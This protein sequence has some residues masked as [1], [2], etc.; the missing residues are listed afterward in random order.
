MTKLPLRLFAA[1][2]LIS[3]SGCGVLP[4]LSSQ[5]GNSYIYAERHE[6]VER[7]TLSWGRDTVELDAQNATVKN[8]QLRGATDSYST[9]KYGP[10]AYSSHLRHVSELENTKAVVSWTTRSGALHSLTLD[11]PK[12]LK[13]RTLH[14]RGFRFEVKESQV[15]VRYGK[16]DTFGTYQYNNGRCYSEL[17]YDEVI[18]K[19][20]AGA[21]TSH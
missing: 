21:A 8:P 15:V 11:I 17:N 1:S 3:L 16:T 9:R 12:A 5:E 4:C 14:S 19:T 10:P 7:L 6:G 20:E 2:A 18:I 13:G